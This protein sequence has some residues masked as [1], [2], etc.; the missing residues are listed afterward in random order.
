MSCSRGSNGDSAG[1]KTAVRITIATTESPKS[2]VRR[3]V[4]RRSRATHS[5]SPHGRG[6]ARTTESVARDG[7]VL[8]TWPHASLEPD[9]RIE[10]RVDDVDQEVD[11]HE[12]ARQ[13]EDRRLHDRVVAVEDR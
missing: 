9:P 6:G 11:D 3:R 13:Q 10:V 12:G 8:T 5:R 2:A 4:K 7:C 1:A